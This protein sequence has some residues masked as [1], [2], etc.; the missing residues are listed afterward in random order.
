MQNSVRNRNPLREMRLAIFPQIEDAVFF[1]EEFIQIS[2][3]AHTNSDHS[4]GHIEITHVSEYFRYWVFKVGKDMYTIFIYS[5]P[6]QQHDVW[7]SHY[8]PQDGE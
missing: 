6:S 2:L 8:L 4:N 5:Y 1:A 3:G 7:Y